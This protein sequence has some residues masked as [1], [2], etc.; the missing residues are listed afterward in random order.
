MRRSAEAAPREKGVPL[1]EKVQ[2]ALHKLLGSIDNIRRLLVTLLIG[3]LAIA[4][5]FP[6]LF[7]IVNA[8]MEQEEIVENY[9]M[10][11]EQISPGFNYG[12]DDGSGRTYSDEANLKLIPDNVTLSQ[13]YTVLMKSPDYLLKFWNSVLIAGLIV[14]GQVIIGALAAFAFAKVRSKWVDALFYL[15]IVMMLMPFQVTLVPNYLMADWLGILNSYAAIILPGAFSTFGV[16]LLRQFMMQVPDAYIE[17]ARLD[18]AGEVKIFRKIVLPMCK[19]GLASLCIL[20][21]IDMWNMVEQPLILL[22]DTALYPLSVFLSRVNSG[23]LGIA[24]AAAAVYMIPVLLVFLYGE[25]YL[26][27]GI[28]HSGVKS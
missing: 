8:F 17:A 10:I 5:L 14:L 18:A 7:T 12:E 2:V 11:L 22:E 1:K 25:K 6:V 27:Q 26:V 24:F 9:G 13:F 4:F 19:P 28:L 20:T 3:V 23:Q 16:F 21:F 15:Y